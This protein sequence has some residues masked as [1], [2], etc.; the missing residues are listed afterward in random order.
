M[1]I[2]G[3]GIGYGADFASDGFIYEGV[4]DRI[5]AIDRLECGNG[6]RIKAGLR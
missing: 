3:N 5:D 4:G 1:V 2:F 6:F